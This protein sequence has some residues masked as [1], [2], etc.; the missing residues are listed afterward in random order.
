MVIQI[1]YNFDP[2]LIWSYHIPF[3]LVSDLFYMAESVKCD[4]FMM[5]EPSSPYSYRINTHRFNSLIKSIVFVP[6]TGIQGRKS[7]DF[8]LN[9]AL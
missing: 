4:Q 3:R 7:L 6:W 1:C 9:N 5:V 8:N 2:M